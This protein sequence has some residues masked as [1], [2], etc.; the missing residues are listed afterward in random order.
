MTGNATYRFA[1]TAILT[2]AAVDAT[3]VVTSAQLDERL[4]DTY[5]R[6]GLRAGLLERL[7]GISER[8]WWDEDVTFVDGAAMA[9]AKALAESGIDA[10][11]V[12]VMIN[13]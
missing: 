9:G 10:A 2:V 12:G 3:R 7:A 1:N 13:T 6:V 4:A 11:R 8:R 5:S